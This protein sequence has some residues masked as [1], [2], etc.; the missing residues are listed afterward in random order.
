MDITKNSSY[1]TWMIDRALNENN[2]TYHLESIRIVLREDKFRYR[3]I[4]SSSTIGNIYFTVINTESTLSWGVFFNLLG[5]RNSLLQ[6]E[7]FKYIEINNESNIVHGY[8]KEF[9]ESNK[10]ELLQFIFSCCKMSLE[11]EIRSEEKII[12]ESQA[13][14]QWLNDDMN[15]IHQFIG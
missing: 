2:I 14:I 15:K 9:I 5:G 4:V 10:N 7:M 13:K 8:V 11:E 1:Y 12:E 3:D 6:Y